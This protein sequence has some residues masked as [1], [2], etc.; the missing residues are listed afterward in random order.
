MSKATFQ[1]S[2]F[3]IVWIVLAGTGNAGERYTGPW[4]MKE[5]AK[6]PKVEWIEGSGPIR[7]L[8]YTGEPYRGKPTRV[9]AFYGAPEAAAPQS[10]R[11]AMVLV[12]GGGGTAFRE[13]VEIWVKRGYAAIAMDLA[14]RR[15]DKTRLPDGGPD[16]GHRQKFDDLAEGVKNAWPYHAVAN[17]VRAASLLES[18]PN[19]DSQRMG[20]TG[21]SWGGYLTCLVA[22]LDGRLKVAVPVYGCGFLHEN[23]AWLKVFDRLG[24]EQTERWV[25]NFDPSQYLANAGMPML[26]VNGSNDFA[27]PLDS[28]QKSYRLVKA[29]R[30]LCITV[31]MPHGHPA[32]WRPKEIGLFVDSVLKSGKSLAEIVTASRHAKAVRVTFKTVVPIKSA[33][34]HYTTD[35][36]AWQKR[37]WKSVPAKIQGD[38]ANAVLPVASGIVYFVTLTDDRGAVVSTE[39]EVV[40]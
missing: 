27:Y 34:L 1:Y 11:P 6:P 25:K 37:E 21:I 19:V 29:P 18:M 10:K 26:F 24:P 15:P 33:A 39:H 4:D 14:G 30:T 9:F 36:G 20:I 12:H 2:A 13:W 38:T 5:L 32:G 8:Y 35:A 40:P 16:Q 17:V 23:S 7:S 31:R 28:Y 3:A 22:G